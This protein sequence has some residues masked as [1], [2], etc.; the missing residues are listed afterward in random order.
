MYKKLTGIG[1]PRDTDYLW[2]YMSF[3]KLANLLYT[4]ALFFTR[5]DKF[6]TSKDTE[7]TQTVRSAIFAEPLITP[8]ILPACKPARFQRF[9]IANPLCPVNFSFF[10]PANPFACLEE[11]KIKFKSSRAVLN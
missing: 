2:R 3:E 11:K 4:K 8:A 5:A 7:Y 10:F 9:K 6:D 1:V